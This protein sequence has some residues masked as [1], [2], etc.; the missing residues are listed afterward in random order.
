MERLIEYIGRFFVVIGF[1]WSIHISEWYQGLPSQDM[2]LWS[3]ISIGILFGMVAW[4]ILPFWSILTD[5]KKI[6]ITQSKSKAN[7]K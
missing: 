4:A 3:F 2:G 6:R 1:V 5:F 7:K